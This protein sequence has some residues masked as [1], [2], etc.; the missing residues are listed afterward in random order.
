LTF[1]YLNAELLKLYIQKPVPGA[2]FLFEN[3][4]W[5]LRNRSRRTRGSQAWLPHPG[6]QVHEFTSSQVHKFTSSRVHG[7]HPGSV[8]S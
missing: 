7:Q 3:E 6:L 1:F 5:N 2:G 4:P 8:T